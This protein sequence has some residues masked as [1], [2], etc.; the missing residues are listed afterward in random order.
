[1]KVTILSMKVS[2]FVG[3]PD[4]T[5]N[6]GGINRMSANAAKLLYAVSKALFDK[7]S[8]NP[9]TKKH[10]RVALADSLMNV[11]MVSSVHYLVREGAV[12]AHADIKFTDGLHLAFSFSRHNKKGKGV[13]IDLIMVDIKR[14]FPTTSVY[15][16][17]EPV[18][19]IDFNLVSL[20]RTSNLRTLISSTVPDTLVCLHSLISRNPQFPDLMSFIEDRAGGKLFYDSIAGKF[21]FGNNKLPF[22][23][24]SERV[25]RLMEFYAL[26]ERNMLRAG[27]YLF[28]QSPENCLNTEIA[29]ITITL[30][31][32]G[33]QIFIGEK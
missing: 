7:G 26:L 29:Q 16:P 9:Y 5:L 32:R 25:C 20:Y 2:G 3:I 10:L 28:W 8:V 12:K 31:A 17:K 14:E 13:N 27:S 22:A 21:S 23:L 30:R 15:L 24:V 6:F 1:M 18:I 19:G 33:V 4:G 11:F